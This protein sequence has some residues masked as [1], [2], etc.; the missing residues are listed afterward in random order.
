MGF[1]YAIA[2]LLH[3]QYSLVEE[4]LER[5]GRTWHMVSSKPGSASQFLNQRIGRIWMADGLPGCEGSPSIG[6]YGINA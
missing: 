4:N 5:F 3:G 6:T 2:R 1:C